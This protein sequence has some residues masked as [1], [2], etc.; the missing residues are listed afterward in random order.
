MVL[1]FYSLYRF[2]DFHPRP[3]GQPIF[4]TIPFTSYPTALLS[5]CDA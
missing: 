5:Y 4:F 2:E 3:H 1:F